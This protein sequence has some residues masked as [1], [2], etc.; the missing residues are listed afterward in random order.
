NCW[1]SDAVN[2]CAVTR[3]IVSA[4]PPGAYGTTILTGFCGQDCAAL[5]CGTK[6]ARG[7]LMA[8]AARITKAMRPPRPAQAGTG[9]AMLPPPAGDGAALGRRG[10]GRTLRLDLVD[11]RR[12]RI[13]L[14]RHD[15]LH[16]TAPAVGADVDHDAVR[17]VVL[18]LVEGV[19]LARRR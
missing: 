9:P 6:M 7:A 18:H 4:L 19:G 1:P 13:G 14:R 3:P 2:H 8:S 15:F 10:C 12:R 11:L 16:R 5:E 17:V